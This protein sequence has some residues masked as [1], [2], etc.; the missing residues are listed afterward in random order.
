MKKV[1]SVLFLL[2]PFCW[3]YYLYTMVLHRSI[4]K[5]VITPL[6]NE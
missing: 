5:S 3:F 4:P 1:A 6:K 2:F